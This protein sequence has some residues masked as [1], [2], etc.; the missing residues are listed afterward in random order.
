[1]ITEMSLR[2]FFARLSPATIGFIAR[3]CDVA[4]AEDRVDALVA[5]SQNYGLGVIHWR[6]RYPELAQGGRCPPDGN[7]AVRCG[8]A[9]SRT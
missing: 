4:D 8:R 3:H 2:K 9:Q 1:M 6:M 5:Y 7:A